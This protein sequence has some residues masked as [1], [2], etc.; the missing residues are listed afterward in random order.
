MEYKK[1]KELV[2]SFEGDAIASCFANKKVKKVR[3]FN[4]TVMFQTESGKLFEVYK[5]ILK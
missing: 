5:S 2:K 4:E 3:E 1:L